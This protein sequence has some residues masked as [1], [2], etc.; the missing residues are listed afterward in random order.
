MCR[1]FL[2]QRL[3]NTAWFVTGKPE[4]TIEGVNEPDHELT[5]AKF[6]AAIQGRVGE[7]LA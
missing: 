4:A 3:Y 6:A 2:I 7:I 5:F 1:R